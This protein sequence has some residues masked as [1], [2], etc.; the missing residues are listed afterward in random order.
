MQKTVFNTLLV[1]QN[2]LLLALKARNLAILQVVVGTY[3]WSLE[4]GAC[5][6]FKDTFQKTL[7]TSV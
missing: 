5:V 4:N 2:S 6:T 7:T 3:V 1:T